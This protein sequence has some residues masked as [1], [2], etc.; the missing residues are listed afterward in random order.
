MQDESRMKHCRLFQKG[1]QD[2]LL[3]F[4]GWGMCPEPFADIPSGGV[5]VLMFYDYR[6]MNAEAT[7]AALTGLCRK[8]YRNVHLLAW[9]MGVR[10]AS[11]LFTEEA[12]LVSELA[13]A[14]AI[15]G[16]CH[17]VHDLLGI[18]EQNF[19]EMAEQ[20]TPARVEAFHRS[21]FSD[22]EETDRFA[23]SFPRGKRSFAELQ[24]ELLVLAGACRKEPEVPDIYTHRIVTGRDRIVPARNQV[25]AWGRRN[26]RTLSLPH[27]PFYQWSSWS[28]MPQ[29]NGAE[30]V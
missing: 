3:F 12:F 22:E 6:G 28:A 5:D 9:S 15:G 2:C 4:A 20:L 19:K 10:A 11:T 30:K 14:I 27:F 25:R 24:E 17:P 8:S 21:M 1:N 16:T 26:C 7:S 29:E 18:P 23:R 13:S